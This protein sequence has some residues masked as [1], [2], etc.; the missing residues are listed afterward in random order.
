MKDD[1][2]CKI[3]PIAPINFFRDKGV[4]IKK[5]DDWALLPI[6]PGRRTKEMVRRGVLLIDKQHP[7]GD[8]RSTALDIPKTD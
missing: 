4:M 3:N 1:L 5:G 7:F 2:K 8:L 6:R